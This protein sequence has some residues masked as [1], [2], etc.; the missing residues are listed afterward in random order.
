MIA[1]LGS[2]LLRKGQVAPLDLDA[3]ATPQSGGKAKVRS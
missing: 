2:I 3:V 1:S